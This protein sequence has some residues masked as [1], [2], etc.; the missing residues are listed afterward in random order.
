[1]IYHGGLVIIALVVV[2]MITISLFLLMVERNQLKNRRMFRQHES[3]LAVVGNKRQRI[4]SIKIRKVTTLL[5][6]SVFGLMSVSLVISDQ[7]RTPYMY[8]WFFAGLVA[9]LVILLVQ[10]QSDD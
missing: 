8:K 1:M 7:L 9:I 2:L 10:G 4:K 6:S 3:G 5:I